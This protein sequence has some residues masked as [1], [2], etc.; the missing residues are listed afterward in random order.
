MPP[1]PNVVVTSP[2]CWLDHTTSGSRLAGISKNAQQFR[3]P[4]A[5]HNVV[6]QRAR[7]VGHVGHVATAAGQVP[8]Q[9]AVHRAKGQ[10]AALGPRPRPRHV[11]QNPLQL[12]AG[13]IGIE[14]QAGAVGNGVPDAALFQGAAQRSGP[15]VLPH[16]RGVDRLACRAIP[17][18][19]RLALVGDA[20]GGHITRPRSDLA[21]RLDRAAQLAGQNFHRIVLYPTRLRVKL[22]ELVLRYGGNRARLVKQN[23]AGTGRSLVQC[24]DV[25]HG[26]CFPSATSQTR[27]AGLRNQRIVIKR[28]GRKP[29]GPRVRQWLELFLFAFADYFARSAHNQN[30]DCTREKES[31][32]SPGP[33][34]GFRVNSRA[35]VRHFRPG[36]S[37]TFFVY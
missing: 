21:Q 19:H 30:K 9:P 34:H 26:C 22:L 37:P 14:H 4:L 31:G 13:E 10:F 7:S 2:T 11:V 20:D 6:E 36:T 28:D 16:N 33:R 8:D 32:R 29:M 5:L 15:A 3:V 17:H 27:G 18:N 12:G 23:R 25:S 24:K 35:E 1:S